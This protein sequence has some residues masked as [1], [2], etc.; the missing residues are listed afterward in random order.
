MSR[1]FIQRDPKNGLEKKEIWKTEV[2]K[3][4]GELKEFLKDKPKAQWNNSI[5]HRNH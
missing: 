4:R 1:I 2:R 5:L 3:I